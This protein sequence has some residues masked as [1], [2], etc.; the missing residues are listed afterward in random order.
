M[1]PS[2]LRLT[3][4][5]L[6]ITGLCAGTALAAPD[7][8]DPRTG[9]AGGGPLALLYLSSSPVMDAAYAAQLTQEGFTHTSATY[10]EPLSMDFLRK[11]NVVVIDYLPIAAEEYNTFGQHMLHF[12]SNMKKLWQCVEEGT[13]VLVYTNLADNGG[14]LAAGWNGEME[15]WGIQLQQSC[16]L[17]RSLAFSKWVAYGENAYAWTENLVAHPVTEGLKRVYYPT[18]NARWDDCYTAPPLLCDGNWTPLVKAMPGARVA[19]LVDN[20]WVYEPDAKRDLV[21]GAVRSV[22]KGRLGVLSINPAYTHRLGYTKLANNNYGEMSFGQVDG[23]ILRKGN[24]AVPSD[25]G[26]LLSRLY[27]WLAGDSGPAG[28][29]GY[30]TGEPVGIETLPPT[31]DEKAFSPVLDPDTMRMPLSWRHRPASVKVGDKQYYPEVSDPLITGDLRFFRGLVGVHSA[32]SD[33]E[34]SV[35]D[36]AAAARQAGYS[37]VVFTENFA[38]LSGADWDKLVADCALAS[39][40]DFVCLPGFDIMDTDNN[41]YLLVAPPYYPRA[42]WLSPD[43]KRLV[44]VQ[45][46]NLLYANHLVI[47]HRAETSPLPQERLK[48]FQGLS[49]YTY[50]GGRLLDESI[51]AYAWQAMNA[52][53]PHPIVVHEV[54][55]PEEVAQAATTGFQQLLPGDTVPNA[56]GYF[57]A[58]LCHYFDSPS[59]YLISEGPIV[60]NWVIN[61]KDYGPAEE[62]RRHFR[63]DIGVKA[64]VPLTTVTLYD[65]FTPIRRW[66]PAGNDFQARADFQHGRQYDLFLI[67]EDTKGQRV[68]TSSMRT[69]TELHHF[70]C[71]DRQN[72]LGHVGAYYTGLNLPNNLEIIMPI[73]GTAEGSAIF[74]N[75][76]GTCMAGKLNFPFTSVDVVLT[77]D[78]L[79][80][81]YV[82][83]LRADVGADAMPSQASKAASVYDATMRNWSFAPGAGRPGYPTIMEFDI[84][85]KREV[86]PVDPQGLFPAFGNLRD[87]QYAWFDKSGKLVSG[88]LGPQ[89]VLDVPVGGYAGG[90]VALTEGMRVDHGRFGLAPA[91]GAPTTLPGGT[92]FVARFLMVASANPGTVTAKGV[93]NPAEWLTA[94]GLAGK[95]P[96][97]LRLTRGKLVGVRFLA[98]IAPD[99]YGS[100]GEVAATADLPFWVPLHLTDLNPRW[101]VGLWREDG[102]LAYTGIF[103]GSAWPRL[104]VGKKGKFYAGN[105]LTADN[106]ELVLEVVK[107]GKDYLKVEAHNPTAAPIEA[108]VSTPRE[109]TTLLPLTRKVTVPAGST[110]Y[111]EAGK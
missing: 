53:N 57:R 46:I 67:A 52:S 42:S 10:Y 26:T 39:T 108:T 56:A 30:K 51:S 61:P 5:L 37:V 74:T 111:V 44:K 63:V 77:E 102:T 79:N 59:R 24:G 97:Q 18:A 107:W 54:F 110:V 22:G 40:E 50:R 98:E 8:P 93:E 48:H 33:G 99:R 9:G 23:I 96:Y 55:S 19:T 88:K 36:Y 6:L 2:S 25:T 7:L 70:R 68:I 100:A 86:Q 11:F 65:G 94:M 27:A 66:L 58:G 72:W 85:L 109:I 1:L 43:G 106:A 76:P 13:G 35:Q 20:Y 17:D 81:K 78:I 69:V 82:D 90:Y 3:L 15:R 83:A 47:A 28:F 64:D 71:A 104:D 14:G 34:G 105:L 12:W 45:M 41:H 31:E 38:Q 16:I 73:E 89:D 95:L 84:R 103:E 101:P 4:A 92:R 60:Y 49:V 91:P 32:F 87:E 21:L 75:V 62:G 80:E 29:G